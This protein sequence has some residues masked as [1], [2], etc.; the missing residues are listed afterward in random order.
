MYDLF[1]ESHNIWLDLKQGSLGTVLLSLK[2]DK[3]IIVSIS[4][5][6]HSVEDAVA[7]SEALNYPAWASLNSIGQLACYQFVGDPSKPL[8]LDPKDPRWNPLRVMSPDCLPLLCD[9]I[10]NHPLF[11]SQAE[12]LLA[13]LVER[14][15]SEQLRS[16]FDAEADPKSAEL[17]RRFLIHL[18]VA[19]GQALSSDSKSLR[20]AIGELVNLNLG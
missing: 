17:Q 3:K 14:I 2:R 20:G 8:F 10:A 11:V 1:D 6:L 15:K 5:A 9:S 18:G 19:T 4:G 13:H 7:V 12:E 16:M